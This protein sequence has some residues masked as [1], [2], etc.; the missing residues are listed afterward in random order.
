MTPVDRR[1]LLR[2]IA[3][4]GV[5]LGVGLSVGVA[6]AQQASAT[7]LLP[8]SS[9]DDWG[10]RP[11]AGTPVVVNSPAARILVH[12]TVMDDT[13][14]TTREQAYTL[15]RDIQNL[16]MDTNGWLDTGQHFTNSKAGFLMEGRHGSLDALRAGDHMIQGAHC[17]GQNSVA[18]GIENQG[19]Y[20]DV[21][22]SVD[23]WQSLVSLCVVVCQQYGVPATEIYGHRDY[24]STTQCPGDKLYAQ[25]P[26]LRSEVAA[27]LG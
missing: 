18:I 13:P 2:G 3:G 5:L 17:P 14:D 26:R 16:H 15:A 7:A 1:T 23:L 20:M 21:E 6:A 22:P 9:C 4:T 24:L 11:P 10:A 27:V 25:L 12:H 19:N 8:I